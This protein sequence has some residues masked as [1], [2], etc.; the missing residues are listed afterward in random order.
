MAVVSQGRCHCTVLQDRCS[1]PSLK[2]HAQR[3]HPSIKDR[4]VWQQVLE[5]HAMLPLTKGH[6]CNKDRISWQKGCPYQRGTTVSVLSLQW[7]LNQIVI[8]HQYIA[9]YQSPRNS[10]FSLYIFSIYCKCNLIHNTQGTEKHSAGLNFQVLLMCIGPCNLR[11][12]HLRTR[13][14]FKTSHG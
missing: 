2:G 7:S 14:S 12:L 9:M 1:C 8:S 13:S 5:M 11:R 10:S 3:G 4:N 6:L